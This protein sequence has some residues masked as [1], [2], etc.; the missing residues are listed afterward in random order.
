MT[1]GILKLK[2]SPKIIIWTK[3]LNFKQRKDFAIKMAFGTG[4]KGI[5]IIG[6]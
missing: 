4:K 6:M 3:K 1:F 2:M 5:G